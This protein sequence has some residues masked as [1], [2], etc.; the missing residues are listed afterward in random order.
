MKTNSQFNK[1]YL[2]LFISLFFIE[3]VIAFYVHDDFIRPYFGDVLVVILIYCF[4]MSFL[5]ISKFKV[6]L[7]VLVL[8]FFVEFAQY[9]NFVTHLGLQDSKLANIVIGNSFALEDLFSYVAGFVVIIMAEYVFNFK[10][11]NL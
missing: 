7:F 1:K 5:T 3:V 9:F 6:A 2:V 11:G 8:A 4:L 10:K